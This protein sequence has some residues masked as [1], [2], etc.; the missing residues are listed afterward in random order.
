MKGST[1]LR[2]VC[3]YG[4]VDLRL[5]P[6][7]CSGGKSPLYGVVTRVWGLY[8]LCLN[9]KRMEVERCWHGATARAS[10]ENEN[11]EKQRKNG[12]GDSTGV[13]KWG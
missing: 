1:G 9:G 7:L 5:R 2:G 11:G 4:A 13:R 10:S 3:L 12:S 6:F 8:G